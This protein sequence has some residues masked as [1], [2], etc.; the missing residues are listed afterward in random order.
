MNFLL[1]WK[2]H[3]QF[4][5]YSIFCVLNYFINFEV[6][7]IMMGILT[8]SKAHFSVYPL[9]YISFGHE[10]WPTNRYSHGIHI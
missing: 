5:G 7:D 8:Q 9:S 2:S 1:L 4:L 3:V 10:T 6:C